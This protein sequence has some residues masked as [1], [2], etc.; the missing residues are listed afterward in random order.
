MEKVKI[1]AMDDKGIDDGTIM[2]KDLLRPAS[3]FNSF[4]DLIG[5][6]IEHVEENNEGEIVLTIEI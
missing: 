2:V 1:Y 3:Q 5:Y 4:E 6:R